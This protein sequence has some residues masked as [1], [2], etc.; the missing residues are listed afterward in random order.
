[1]SKFQGY[2]SRR[3]VLKYFKI[4]FSDNNKVDWLGIVL[5]LTNRRRCVDVRLIQ[6]LSDIVFTRF[7]WPLSYHSHRTN[8][9]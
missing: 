3:N 8:K 6:A 7:V 9:I 5:L 2:G 4:F 1:M